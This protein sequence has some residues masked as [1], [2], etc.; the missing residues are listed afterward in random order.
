MTH[1]ATELCDL[2]QLG[3]R[4]LPNRMNRIL[5]SVS[6]GDA[7]QRAAAETVV[8]KLQQSDRT[9]SNQ[10]ASERGFRGDHHGR[11]GVTTPVLRVGYE[12]VIEGVDDGNVQNS[13]EDEEAGFRG[14]VVAMTAPG[15]TR[16]Q[17]VDEP[18]A[19]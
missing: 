14:E 1:R 3:G 19:R 18:G 10:T 13:L 5:T 11:Q 15:W 7:Q 17:K 2:I 8:M 12:A 16:D 9:C 6:S 4:D